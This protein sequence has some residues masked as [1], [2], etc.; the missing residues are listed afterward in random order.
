AV[1][2]TESRETVQ[3]LHD[4]SFTAESGQMVA[5]VGPSGAGKTTIT[6]LASRPYD[7]GSGTVRVGGQDV[8]DVTLESLEDV[9]G[10]VTQDAHMFHDTIRA[11]LLYARPE[12]TDDEIWDALEAAQIARLVGALPEGLDTV[13]GDRG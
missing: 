4:I 9:V 13:V 12:A 3:V 10:Y 7:V 1:A 2:R 6:N 5:L 11:K 8:R